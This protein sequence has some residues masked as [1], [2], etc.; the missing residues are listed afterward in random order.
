[1][2]YQYL[3]G[4]KS[5]FYMGKCVERLVNTKDVRGVERF[6]F[7]PRKVFLLLALAGV[8]KNGIESVNRL[9]PVKAAQLINRAVLA[10]MTQWQ[11]L[12]ADEDLPYLNAAGLPAE[13]NEQVKRNFR[14]VD[15]KAVLAEA[16][17][18]A[19]EARFASLRFQT[20]INPG[21]LR[22]AN[23]A[24]FTDCPIN[25]DFL[26]RGYALVYCPRPLGRGQV[27]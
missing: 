26:F 13:F 9:G 20:G 25:V 14:A 12:S 2:L 27:S 17:V 23:A 22:E 24:I 1:M 16:R 21:Q 8:R 19:L 7:G 6:E 4:D 18:P 10:G 5:T 15:A 3:K 11:R